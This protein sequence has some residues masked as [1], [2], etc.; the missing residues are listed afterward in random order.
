VLKSKPSDAAFRN[1]LSKKA[2][3]ALKSGGTDVVG[4]S[5]KK[6][7]VQVTAGGN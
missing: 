6:A 2:A 5:F 4:S 3:D 7:T 1:D